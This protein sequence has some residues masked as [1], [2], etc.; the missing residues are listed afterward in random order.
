MSDKWQQEYSKLVEFTGA[1]P[2]ILINQRKVII[3]E[4]SRADFYSL[5]NTVRNAFVKEYCPG[6]IK[7]STAIKDN[8]N[9]AAAE[10]TTFN[11]IKGISASADFD[12]F[13]QN[14][15][16]AI[17]RPLFDPLF[18][19]LKGKINEDGFRKTAKNALESFANDMKA[20]VYEKWIILNIINL[21]KPD[22][23]YECSP[24]LVEN[25]RTE[26]LKK[27]D[28]DSTL[29]VPLVRKTSTLSWKFDINPQLTLADFI[30]HSSVKAQNKYIAIRSRFRAAS[31][32]AEALNKEREWLPVKTGFMIRDDVILIYMS[33]NLQAISLVADNKHLC[34]PDYFIKYRL[35]ESQSADKWLEEARIV[36]EKLQPKSGFHL[37]SGTA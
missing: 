30:M 36:N 24:E 20:S 7:E 29:E 5:F 4:D 35:N 34:R 2:E 18:D 9:K 12:R 27:L 26:I 23:L 13:I 6:T 31:N 10:A 14:P 3:P 33:D 28:H 15:E 19:L 37:V 8:Y 11:C 25:T 1:R 17:T 32:P 16:A 21:L 22:E